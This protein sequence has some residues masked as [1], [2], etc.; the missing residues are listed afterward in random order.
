MNEKI[1]NDMTV[2]ELLDAKFLMEEQ[3]KKINE[4]IKECQVALAD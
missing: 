4:L 1:I 3:S 2:D